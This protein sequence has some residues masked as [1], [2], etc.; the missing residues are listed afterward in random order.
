MA[1]LLTTPLVPVNFNSLASS[2]TFYTGSSPSAG[3]DLTGTGTAFG[4]AWGSNNV[5]LV[6][7]TSGN[8]MLWYSNTTATAGACQV[9]VGQIVAGQVLPASTTRTIAATESGWIGPFNA[10]TY[11]IKNTALVPSGIAG[12]PSIASWPQAA[13]GCWAVA[14]TTPANL[15]VRAYTFSNA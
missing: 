11:N 4:T 2:G 15:S 9:L 14:F 5:L 13:V 7:N 3:I 6:P 12:T 8:V 10:G 1:G